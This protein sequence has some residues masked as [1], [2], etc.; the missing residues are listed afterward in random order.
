LAHH[1]PF[2]APWLS[3]VG[4]SEVIS[5]ILHPYLAPSLPPF[6]APSLPCLDLALPYFTPFLLG[7]FAAL[8]CFDIE[9][10][11]GLSFTKRKT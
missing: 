7:A 9:C 2:A 5:P 1:D 10:M 11:E 4:C 8:D 6:V 3:F